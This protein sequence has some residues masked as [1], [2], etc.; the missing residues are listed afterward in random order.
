MGRFTIKVHLKDNDVEMWFATVVLQKKEDKK[1][2][3]EEVL[4]RHAGEIAP[5]EHHEAGHAERRRPTRTS[6][7]TPLPVRGRFWEDVLHSI[8]PSGTA[9]QMRTFSFG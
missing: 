5:T 2:A 4:S 7:T 1:K 8:D 6:L 9:A 3:I